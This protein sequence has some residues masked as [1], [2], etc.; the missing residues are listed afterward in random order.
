M[1][2]LREL[3]EWHSY[4]IDHHPIY[5]YWSNAAFYTA[6]GLALASGRG[7]LIAAGASPSE[8]LQAFVQATRLVA[9]LYVIPFVLGGQ[10]DTCAL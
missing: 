9:P 10:L 6:V 8:K 5:A 4:N 2:S 1:P 3:A 7:A